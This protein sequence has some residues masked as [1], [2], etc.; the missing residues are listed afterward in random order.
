[1]SPTCVTHELSGDFLVA[2]AATEDLTT[3]SAVVATAEGCELLVAVVTLFTLAV[4]HPV[5]LQITVLRGD[6]NHIF[7]L[8]IHTI[9]TIHASYFLKNNQQLHNKKE[10][11]GNNL[12]IILYISICNMAP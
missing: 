12:Y 10:G 9:S 2:A 11:K 5:L 7:I 1:M 8:H 6:N 4:W 3:Q